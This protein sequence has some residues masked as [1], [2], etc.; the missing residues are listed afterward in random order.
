MKILIDNQSAINLAKHPV[1]HCR[2]KHIETRFYNLR[3]QVMKGKIDVEFCRSQDQVADVMTK[4]LRT[5][6]F[7]ELREMLEMK[8]LDDLN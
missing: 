7:K 4:A 5:E 1:A 3:D 6:K 2:T 8:D